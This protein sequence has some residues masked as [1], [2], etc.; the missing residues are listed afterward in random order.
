MDN[1]RYNELEQNLDSILTEKELS[2][3]WHWCCEFDFLLVGPGMTEIEFCLCEDEAIKK[4][5]QKL[6]DFQGRE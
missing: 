3:G 2:E 5:K 4:A 6:I 1:K